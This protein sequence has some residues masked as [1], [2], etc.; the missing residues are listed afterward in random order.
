MP[1]PTTLATRLQAL[2]TARR[3]HEAEHGSPDDYNG[4]VLNDRGLKMRTKAYNDAWYKSYG[5]WD[6]AYVAVYGR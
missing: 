2:A 5:D 6:D 1:I 3:A 4:V